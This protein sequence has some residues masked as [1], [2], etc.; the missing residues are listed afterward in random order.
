MTELKTTGHGV[1]PPFLKKVIHKFENLVRELSGQNGSLTGMDY[2]YKA[3]KGLYDERVKEIESLKAS[4]TKIVGV[5]CNFV[6]EELVY[7]AGAVPIRICAGLQ[8]T[9][10]TSEE[11]LPRNFCPLIKSSLGFALE[12]SPHF[13]LADVIIIPTTCDGK[14]KLSEILGTMKPTWT[15]EVPHTMETPQARELWLTELGLLRTQLEK[16]TGKRIQ[17]KRLRR[18]IEKANAKRAAL[19]RF[20]ELRKRAPPPIWGRDALLVTNLC[21]FDDSERWTRHVEQLCDELEKKGPV[22]D[23][24]NPRIFLTGCPTVVPTWKIP[25]LLEES[26]GI[27]V[28]DDICPG[29]KGLWDPVEVSHWGWSDMLIGLADRYLMNTCACF[30]PN[31]ARMD[32]L[33]RYLADFNVEGVIY[34]TLMACHIYGMEIY[35]IE[36]ALKKKNIPLL[37]IETDYSQEDVEQ[38]RTRM[39]AFIEMISARKGIGMLATSSM[40]KGAGKPPRTG[41]KR[42][43]PGPPSGAAAVSFGTKNAPLKRGP[44]GPPPAK[45]LST[46]AENDPKK[47]GPPG[48]PPKTASSSLPSQG[49]SVETRGP[50]R[51]QIHSPPGEEIKGPL[52]EKK[53]S[54]P[55]EGGNVP[56]REQKLSPPGEGGKIPL[57]DRK[58]SPPGTKQGGRIGDRK[59]TEPGENED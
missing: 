48:P 59:L 40:S 25:L 8:D 21:F 30:T 31:M 4:G 38:I 10:L 56:L 13:E 49:K 5:L 47:R 1:Q 29:S 55:G 11:I 2:F 52:R 18:E 14:K 51:Q 19:R 7:A 36:N 58:L 57:R 35:R 39:E 33:L 46:G 45:A 17:K 12:R 9:I 16:L 6:P 28:G 43:P 3:A 24:S 15:L 23:G 50:L 26:G 22:T 54:P 34:Y 41:V 53:L 44:P 37:K 42:G 32:R 20:Y 27:I